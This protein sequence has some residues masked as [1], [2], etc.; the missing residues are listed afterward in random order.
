MRVM[1]GGYR[2]G[3]DVHQLR[4]VIAAAQREVG[5]MERAHAISALQDSV[6]TDVSRRVLAQ[7]VQLTP[8]LVANGRTILVACVAGELRDDAAHRLCD[9]LDLA[10]FD[11]RFLGASVP[12]DDLADR[13][14]SE[15]PDLIALS[16]TVPTW[17]PA[18][19]EAVHAVRAVAPAVPLAL[20]AGDGTT[21]WAR[22]LAAELA[23]AICASSD[24]ELVRR[25]RVT[26][27]I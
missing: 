14:R 12:A 8:P 5:G 6:A 22:A 19:R 17:A 7:M 10:G 16:L 23:I 24:A 2:D 15:D 26:L 20:D 27:G 18:L 13:V 4:A 1:V 11:I 21:P 3:A 25:A 9:A